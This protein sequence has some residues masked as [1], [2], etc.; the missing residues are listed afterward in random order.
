MDKIEK[1]C[2]EIAQLKGVKL[3][4]FSDILS[5]EPDKSLEE[6]AMDA[7]CM[8]FGCD[9]A[10]YGNKAEF[11]VTELYQLFVAGSKW[12]AE[13]DKDT[14]ELAEEHAYFAGAVNEREQM[15]KEA[16]EGYVCAAYP[17]AQGNIIEYSVKYP[18]DK[19][20]YKFGDKVRIIVC[21]K[22]D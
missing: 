9:P 1:I 22:E 3:Y 4:T 21:K 19:Y 20:P 7:I 13:K 14:I 2:Q 16:V 5:E 6:A 8:A 10:Y 15:M 11:S 12:Q 18:K 17:A